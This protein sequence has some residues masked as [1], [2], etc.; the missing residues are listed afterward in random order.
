MNILGI[1]SSCDET[2]AAVVGSGREILSNIIVSQI[3]DHALYGGVVPEIASRKHIETIVPV[4]NAALDEASLTLDDI[5]GIAVT[6]GPGLVGSLL[7]GLSTAKAIAFSKNIPLVGV[8]H[9]EGHLTAILL[10]EKIDFPYIG[11]IVS[12]G[13]TSL[14]LV[15]A[16]GDYQVLGCTIDDAA[17]EALDKVAKVMGLGYPG[18]VA[19]DRLSKK[20]NPDSI[21]FPR[22][23]LDRDNLDFSFSG[24]KTAA[25]QFIK[26]QPAE[27]LPD[28]INDL[29]ASFLEAVVDV[30]VKKSM[31]AAGEYN[32][33]TIVVSGGVACNSRLREVMKEECAAMGGRAFFPSPVLCTDNAAMIAA[34]GYHYLARG[35][36]AGFDMNAVARWEI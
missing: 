9:I 24:M 16:V 27:V 13:H 10:E 29:S 5:D 36:R 1:E 20:G 30:L 33:K 3:R 17:G 12:G 2:A 31:K 11:L 28:M 26:K 25:S 18:G 21:A 8:N 6:K 34:L 32:V 15:K 22:G 35:D 19:I 7:I 4:I 23:L 14:Y